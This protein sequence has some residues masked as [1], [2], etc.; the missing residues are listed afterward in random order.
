MIRIGFFE[1]EATE[2][3]VDQYLDDNHSYGTCCMSPS[4]VNLFEGNTSF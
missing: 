4:D 1:G 2:I 3:R